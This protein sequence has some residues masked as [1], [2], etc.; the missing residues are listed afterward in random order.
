MAQTIIFDPSYMVDDVVD[1]SNIISFVGD[2]TQEQLN[3]GY[4]TT[5]SDLNL[6]GL[7]INAHYRII[8]ASTKP[9]LVK[10]SAGEIASL[11]DVSNKER[12]RNE[13]NVQREVERLSGIEYDGHIF[14]SDS[15]S[16][17]NING[18]VTR[19]LIAKSEGETEWNEYWITSN[20]E[21]VQLDMNGIIGLGKAATSF[22]SNLYMKY[23]SLK[24]AV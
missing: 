4:R 14:D 21:V 1:G 7:V 24:D 23:K 10:K 19:V 12:R 15:V 9:E 3:K 17:Q 11:T 16:L 6:H 8:N 22:I 2:I 13:L 20:N 5:E 18:A